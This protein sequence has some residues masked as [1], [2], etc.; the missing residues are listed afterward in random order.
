MQ[1]DTH[2]K[3]GISIDPEKVKEVLAAGGKLPMSELL[4]CRVRYFTDGVVL[5][6]KEFVEDVF[7]QYRNE[8]GYKRKRGAKKP[9]YGEWGELYTMRDL[10]VDPVTLS[11]P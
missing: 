7:K 5:G 1:A 3:K 9:R 10:R 6:G 8:F 4:H 11:S 2:R